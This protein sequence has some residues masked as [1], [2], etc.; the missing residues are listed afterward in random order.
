M[1]YWLF[2]G[3]F[4]YFVKVGFNITKKAG[5]AWEVLDIEVGIVDIK[6]DI[7]ITSV[8]FNPEIKLDIYLKLIEKSY[9][10]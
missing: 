1:L 2:L 4:R 3:F 9:I 8:R 6:A 7:T 10:L 5:L